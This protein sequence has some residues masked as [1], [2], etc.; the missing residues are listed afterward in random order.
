MYLFQALILRDY[1]DFIPI[2]DI[3]SIIALS[4]SA[5]HNLDWC[6]KAFIRLEA[7]DEISS[8]E[9]Q[10]FQDLAMEIFTEYVSMFVPNVYFLLS[11]SCVSPLREEVMCANCICMHRTYMSL[12]SVTPM[13]HN[14]Q[15]SFITST[16][17][18]VEIMTLTKSL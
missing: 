16:G 2:K 9:R 15:L 8:R 10:L 1:E 7:M 12:P 14:K 13:K 3:Y 6:S 18:L 4:S 5:C 17:H 11:C